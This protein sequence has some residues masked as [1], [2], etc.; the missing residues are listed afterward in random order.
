[1][2]LKIIW[3]SSTVRVDGIYFFYIKLLQITAIY[4][5]GSTRIIALH[6]I[7]ESS[8]ELYCVVKREEYCTFM[9]RHRFYGFRGSNDNKGSLYL[10]LC[11]S[12]FKYIR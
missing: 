2:N 5:D 12:Y 10:D 4:I 1:M 6:Q 11:L 9:T 7:K 8:T 3:F